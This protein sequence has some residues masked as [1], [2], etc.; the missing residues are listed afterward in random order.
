MS[1][2]D[3]SDLSD[4]LSLRDSMD[5]DMDPFQPEQIAPVDKLNPRPGGFS[6]QRLLPL[7]VRCQLASLNGLCWH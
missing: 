4:N 2:D 5:V 7:E 3:E 1:D 6:V